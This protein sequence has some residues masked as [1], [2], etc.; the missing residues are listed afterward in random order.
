[1]FRFRAGDVRSLLVFTGLCCAIGACGS[2]GGATGVSAGQTSPADQPA[3]ADRGA[4]PI[5][6]CSLVSADDV[7]RLLQAPVAG[8][9]FGSV[10]CTWKNPSTYESVSVEIGYADTAVD[11]TLAPLAPDQP[12]AGI[13]AP[14]GMRFLGTGLVEFPAGGRSNTVQIAVPRMSADD[15]N[16]AAI[17]LAR[18]IAPQIPN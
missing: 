4:T 8:R 17:E 16:S 5:D 10:S 14:D 11:N 3:A 1:M 15:A 2:G 9:P 7:E 6:I 18:K 13:P 12:S